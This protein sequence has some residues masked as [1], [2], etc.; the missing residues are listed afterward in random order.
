MF[1]TFKLFVR[2]KYIDT[3]ATLY[4]NVVVIYNKTKS[5]LKN[6]AV[7]VWLPMTRPIKFSQMKLRKSRQICLFFEEE[8]S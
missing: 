3:K 2:L 7:R 4:F 1:E 6:L 8:H 5:S